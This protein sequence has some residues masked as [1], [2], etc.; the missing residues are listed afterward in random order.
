MEH[1]VGSLKAVLKQ[2]IRD[3]SQ[4][5][6]F[7]CVLGGDHSCQDSED[8]NIERFFNGV[9]STYMFHNRSALLQRL[10][11]AIFEELLCETRPRAEARATV[12][13]QSVDVTQISQVSSTTTPEEPVSTGSAEPAI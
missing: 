5:R 10:R 2:K 7:G 12:M 6:C 4:N 13:A 1:F 11:Q 3:R 9:F 8:V